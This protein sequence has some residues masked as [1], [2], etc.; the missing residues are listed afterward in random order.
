M[1]GLLVTDFDFDLPSELI[2]QQ[3][4]TERGLS[5]MLL[6]DRASG[7]LRDSNFANFPSLLEPG[8]CWCSTTAG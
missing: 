8:D 6:V 1:S 4:P 7:A 2:A 3:P 5:R